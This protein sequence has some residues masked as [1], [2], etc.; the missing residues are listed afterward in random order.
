MNRRKRLLVS[1]PALVAALV[2]AASAPA[3]AQIGRMRGI[4]IDETGEPIRGATVHATSQASYPKDL[5]TTTDADGRFTILV[6]RSGQWDL[7]IE[8]PGFA[9]AT[10]SVRV[11]LDDSTQRPVVSIL[12]RRE[13][14][15]ATGALAGANPLLIATELDAAG[16]LFAAGRYDDAIAAYR[17]IQVQTPALT[18]VRLQLGNAYLQKKDY[19]RAEVEFQGLL[20]SNAAN[21]SA[22]YNL[23]E[24]KAARGAADEAASWY[25]KAA[26]ADPLWT[27]PLMRLAVLARDSGNREAAI[28]YL[29]K[30]VA[31]APGSPDATQAASLLGQFGRVD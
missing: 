11:R 17:K 30:V 29:K 7:L 14:P 4:V 26:A 16:R 31:L 15:E 1:V 18:A 8:A 2:L 13:E 21:G 24:V 20:K 25:Q 3:L 5:R 6:Q 28:G 22:C 12:V 27:R 19:D 10:G 9:S 23:G